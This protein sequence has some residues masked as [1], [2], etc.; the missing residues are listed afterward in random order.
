MKTFNIHLP[1]IF[2]SIH[3]VV[4][5]RH[6]YSILIRRIDTKMEAQKIVPG[7]G[8]KRRKT[9]K[10]STGFKKA[11]QAPKRFKSPYIL[12]SI[13]KMQKYRVLFKNAKVTSF[14]SLISKEWK[15]R[16]PLSCP[17]FK[18]LTHSLLLI[19]GPPSTKTAAIRISELQPNTT[20][21]A[22][23]RESAREKH[24]HIEIA[25]QR[26]EGR[27]PRSSPTPHRQG[28]AGKS[29][30]SRED[31]RMAEAATEIK[32]GGGSH[33]V[34]TISVQGPGDISAGIETISS[35]RG[36]NIACFV[37][38]YFRFTRI[39][40]RVFSEARAIP[41]FVIIC[42]G[43]THR[44]NFVYTNARAKGFPQRRVKSR[45]FSARASTNRWIGA[46]RGIREPRS[47]IRIPRE[48][49]SLRL[50]FVCESAAPVGTK[51]A[52]GIEP[53]THYRRRRRHKHL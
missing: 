18:S 37:T 26:M 27:P 15:A 20:C 44:H 23:R 4:P 6:H 48:L 2:F 35:T 7:P 33:A 25:W 1:Q 16:L 43:V 10:P 36:I 46:L 34:R 49:F 30:I 29:G 9:T 50:A 8:T 47:C 40:N 31:P 3:F 45:G 5:N 21:G 19:V 53:D 24:G 41:S 11:P 42:L 52:H 32:G 28:S 39:H 17:D 13:S 38:I 22:D 12:F 14:S 51:D